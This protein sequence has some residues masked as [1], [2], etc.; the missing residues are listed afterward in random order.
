MHAISQVIIGIAVTL[1]AGFFGPTASAPAQSE[2]RSSLCRL[3]V[4]PAELQNR[5]KAD[6][7]DWKVQ[8]PTNLSQAA[9]GRWRDEKP[10][11]CPGI[12]VGRFVSVDQNAYAV[13]LVPKKN[14]DSAYRLLVLTA[15][16]GS[17]AESLRV[18]NQ[19]DKGGASNN[20]I[21]TIQVD[22]V[23][24]KEWIAKLKVKITYAILAVDSGENEYGAEVYFWADG[25]FK[26]EPIDY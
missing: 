22:K 14:P 19:L 23:F 24:S 20:F 2:S 11:T 17:S 16:V 25:Q 3:Q 21:H 15:S 7:P 12:A 18:V 4:I 1:L 10:L 8:D 26:H 5:L 9:R 13:L 6:S